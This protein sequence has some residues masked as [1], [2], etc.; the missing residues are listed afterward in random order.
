MTG[1]QDRYQSQVSFNQVYKHSHSSYFE[2]FIIKLHL[3]PTFPL[4]FQD[5]LNIQLR[6]NSQDKVQLKEKEESISPREVEFF[7]KLPKETIR[8]L[9]QFYAEDFEL[10]GYSDYEKFLALGSGA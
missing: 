6:S 4:F 7:S 9:H 8:K 1:W 2:Y 5:I 10:F 3:F